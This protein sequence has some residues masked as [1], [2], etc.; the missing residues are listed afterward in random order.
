MNPYTYKKRQLPAKKSLSRQ[1]FA[2][3]GEAFNQ[4]LS[5]LLA[6]AMVVFASGSVGAITLVAYSEI[7]GESFYSHAVP[8]KKPVGKV[9][10]SQA[11]GYMQPLCQNQGCLG[12][13]F[14]EYNSSS[15]AWKVRLDYILPQGTTGLIRLNGKTLPQSK[16]ISGNGSLYTDFQIKT[17]EIYNFILYKRVTSTTIRRLVTISVTGANRPMTNQPSNTTSVPPAPAVCDYP[18]ARTGCHWDFTN[19]NQTTKCGA[20]LVCTNNPPPSYGY[21]TPAVLTP[22]NVSTCGEIKNPGTYNL[23]QDLNAEPGQSC[24]TIHDTKDVTLDCNNK[25]I[26]LDIT[27]GNASQLELK[28]VTG[29][30]IKDCNLKTLNYSSNFVTGRPLVINNGSNGVLTDNYYGHSVTLV[31]DSKNLVFKNSHFDSGI[32]IVSSQNVTVSNNSFKS[33]SGYYY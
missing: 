14:T 26:S 10:G 31:N 27:K 16:N 9:L 1:T 22:G 5:L 24:I 28:N 33:P 13:G 2:L 17:D 8:M 19:A 15:D 21:Y 18:E 30:T 29:F 12:Y 3:I 6:L 7:S 25:N 20:V 23:T 32:Q 4:P 11:Y